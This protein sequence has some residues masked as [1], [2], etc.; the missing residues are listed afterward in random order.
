MASSRT[1]VPI[2]RRQA[3]ALAGG[4]VAAALSIPKLA[5]AQ[6]TNRR[7]V[8]SR[9]FNLPGWVDR[10]DGIAPSEVVLEKL[11]GMGFETVRLPVN[12]DLIANGDAAALRHIREG[13]AD[14][15]RHG[16]A[17]IVDMHPSE[18]LHAA[19]RLDFDAGAERVSQ[20]WTA[21]RSVIADLSPASVY[22]ELLNEPPLESQA[23]LGLRDR[24]AEIVR[25][26]CPHHTLVWGPSPSQGIWEIGQ[27][28]PLAD[29]NQIAAIHFYAPTAFTHQCETWDA[30]P[31]ARIS[32]LPFPATK[33]TPDVQERIKAL[34]TA[35]DEQAAALIE[36]QLS[37]PW[38]EAAISAEFAGLKRWSEA[39]ECPVIMNEFGVLNF[40]V[41]AE[42]RVAWVR[43]VRRAAEVHQVGWVHWELDQG[44]GFIQSRR[45]ADGFDPLMTA[46][47]LG[48][49]GGG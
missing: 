2:S 39:H 13:V 10:S 1:S 43:A 46:A 20:A 19:L 40:C 16:F 27:T 41:G 32:N 26:G 21:L 22:P 14:L 30:S 48:S 11:R 18:S 6:A 34:R 5:A 42:S 15:V 44:F 33:E 36:E 24:L 23:W 7:T 38:T 12:G 4:S 8:P 45:S 29:D 25:S 28:P 9:G 17:V 47:L 3:L 49:D 35:G 31:L 37:T